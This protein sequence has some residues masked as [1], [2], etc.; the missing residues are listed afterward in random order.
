MSRMRRL[1][2]LLLLLCAARSSNA[3]TA[4][5]TPS[6]FLGMQIGADRTL[7]D[8]RQMSSY[9][10]ALD[11]A[12]PRVEVVSLGKTTLGE[13]MLM[14]IIS[15]EAN[16]RNKDRIR[17]ISRRLAD[18]R[19]LSNAEIDA[20]VREG[21]TI[22]LMTLNIH[23]TEIASSQMSMEL[24]HDL[25]TATDPETLRRLEN[26]VLLLIP[27]L[28]PDGQTME[29][30]WYR[31]QK[32]TRFEGGRM[33]WLYH[34]YVGH[35]NN[36]DWFMLTQKET[37]ALSRMIYHEWFPQVFVDQHQMG[38]TAPRMFIPPF[39][40]PLDADVH[41]LIW[42]EVNVIGS[43]MAFRL[44]QAEKAGVIYGY[45]YD[46]YWIGGTRNT[47]WWKNITGLLT[48]TA[49]A[50]FATPI[51]VEP[52]DL[53][54]GSKGLID[55]QATINHPNPWKGGWWRMRD[56][57]DYQRIAADAMIETCADRRE[58]FLRNLVVRAK[59]AASATPESYVIPMSQR[60]AP[61]AKRLAELMADHGVNVFR[62]ANGDYWIP[63]DQPYS[64]FVREMLERQRYPE[65]RVTEGR[66][67]LRPYDVSAWSLP[68][69]MDVAVEKRAALPS[70]GAQKVVAPILEKASASPSL[71]LPAA[72]YEVDLGSPESAR[73]VN[74][75]LRAG[76]VSVVRGEDGP[77]RLFIDRAGAN[78]AKPVIA[79][80]AIRV[81]PA[82]SMSGTKMR[83]PRVAIYKPWAASMDE[84][85]TRW[86]LEQYGF[87]PKTLDNKTI[88]AGNLGQSYD[89]IILP[90]M[91]KEVIMTGRP[92]TDASAYFQELPGEYRGGLEK[93][94]AQA[95]KTF[96]EAGGT[97]IA[98]GEANAWVLQNFNVPVRNALAAAKKED[99]EVNGS[100]L[101]VHVHRSHPI[102]ASMPET[103]SVFLDES[104]AF[105]T[106]VPGTEMQRWVLATYPQH[107]DE[108]LRSGWIHGAERLRR[109]AAA[110]AMTY[111]KGKLVLLG[112]RPQ[113]R[114]QT[115]ATFPF[116]FNSI[117]WS[118]M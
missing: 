71:D 82:D 109:R 84:G 104:I 112:F 40:D 92:G 96:V 9:F 79:D 93:E 41:P 66:D 95:L 22:A 61:S 89:A 44:E 58:D 78:A 33:P 4:I 46:A 3:Q 56:I 60:N 59:T 15:S 118:V 25:A 13:E 113:N 45:Q 86:V 2:T 26:V 88:R 117:Y 63:L 28:N 110:I 115:H 69:L 91:S 87:D 76:A 19:G 47:G 5:R 55:Y 49:S 57:M 111:E 8:Y 20:L 108:I 81:T 72:A 23:S 11:A 97:L 10:R 35:D 106:S 17:E 31:K 38:P 54:G 94:G 7:A 16:I 77:M 14:A 70:D 12:S 50:R 48:E 101:T 27:S 32:G 90:S 116:V 18:P 68:L 114:A 36:R 34:H 51:Y 99:F 53:R 1:L 85:W 75:A 102:T 6:D 43:N 52:I 42:R 105:E 100:L 62:A 98:F 39:S 103:T 80:R 24:A 30:E 73:V 83:T 37:R 29:T 67:I 21:K 74:Q 64:R 65:V 107:T